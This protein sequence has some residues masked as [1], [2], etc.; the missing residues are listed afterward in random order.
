MTTMFNQRFQ[1]KQG[2]R[3]G[4]LLVCA[5]LVAGGWGGR[6]GAAKASGEI[7]VQNP[8]PA[9]TKKKAGV[10]PAPAGARKAAPSAQAKSPRP[11]RS[12]P[13]AERPAA[14]GSEQPQAAI[15][16]RRDPFKIPPPPPPTPA[17]AAGLPGPMPG[18]M[19]GLV[20]SQ[21]VLEGIVRM[22][23]TN[24]MIA[25]VTNYTHRAYFLRE[26][27]VLYNGVVSKITPDAVYFRENH[28]DQS[29]RVTTSEVVKRLG[30]AS[31]EGR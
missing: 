13:P 16:G 23:T 2:T 18:G 3:A 25:V 20:I 7:A 31:G 26:N 10:V 8:V 28:L 27:D 11:H 24:Q 14:A 30:P 19:K 15:A 21:L 9:P 22:D 5:I 12:K 1:P 6:T 17:N 29:G 4:S